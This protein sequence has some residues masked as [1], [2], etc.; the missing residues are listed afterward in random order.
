[1]PL[2]ATQQNPV[3]K[4]LEGISAQLGHL[5]PQARHEELVRIRLRIEEDMRR[6]ERTPPARFKAV[7]RPW[8]LAP[9][10]AAWLGVCAGIAQHLGVEALHVRMAALALGLLTGPFALLAYIVAYG[11]LSVNTPDEALRRPDG[12]RAMGAVASVTGGAILFFMLA[13]ALSIM[14]LRVHGYLLSPA[15]VAVPHPWDWFAQTGGTLLF[16]TVLWSAPLAVL[17]ALP[18]A[19]QWDT[20]LRKVALAVVALMGIAAAFGVACLLVGAMTQVLPS[21]LGVVIAPGK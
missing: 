4:Y 13:Q 3:D 21:T 6:M 7:L 15:V 14:I 8:S 2:P 16:W 12:W 20:T 18:L 1:M 11:L 17:G 19:G 5:P 10:E 9:R